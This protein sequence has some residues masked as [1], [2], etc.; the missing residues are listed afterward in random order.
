MAQAQLRLLATTDVHVYLMGYDYF[1]DRPDDHV[2]LARTAT[3]IEAARAEVRNSLLFDNGD[4]LQGNPMGDFCVRPDQ[5]PDW[6]VHPAI[7]VMNRLR[8]DAATLGNHEF[9]YGLD[10]LARLLRGHDFPVVSANIARRLGATPCEDDSYLPPWALLEREIETEDGRRL[11]IR[12]GVI[13]FAPPQIVQWDR[14]FLEGVLVTRG[15]A[16]AAAARVP[17]L[18]A[19]GADIVVALSHSGIGVLEEGSCA[20]NASSALAL[21]PGIDAIIAGHSHLCFPSEA[22]A[23]IEGVDLERSTLFGVPTVMPGFYGSHLGMIDLALEHHPDTG[24]QVRDFAANLREVTPRTPSL[25]AITSEIAAEHEATIEHARHVVGISTLPMQSYFATVTPSAALRVV[26]EAQAQY[27]AR[28]LAGRPEAELPVLAAASPFKAGGRGGP[29]NYTNVPAGELVLRHVADLYI[30]PNTIAALRVTGA[31]LLEWLENSVGLYHQVLPGAQDAPLINDDFPSYNHDRILGLSFTVDLSLP[32]R[33]DRFGLL[34]HPD[35]H[36]VRDLR[37]LRQPIDP[38][39][40]FVLATNSY[41]AA[42]CGGY[43]AARPER[44]IDVGRT[45]IREILT[46]YLR[47]SP[48][49]SPGPKY[50]F[51]FC[52][53]PGTSVIFDTAPEATGFLGDIAGYRPEPLGLQPSGFTRFRLHL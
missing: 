12:I 22:F 42:G 23:G 36:R 21:V 26:A 29:G 47:D 13:G 18:R 8:Y 49:F 52:P 1:A 40:E 53:M 7:R 28:Q 17:Q 43:T 11:P 44:L 27:V 30:Y 9:N 37:Y 20:E 31:D 5:P 4:F 32:P 39:Q 50:M 2:G 48:P 46:R 38:A 45:P 16:E 3:L 25:P 24:W 15:I 41:R 33:Y 6:P 14:Q 51:T 10:T 35:V 34:R 19:A